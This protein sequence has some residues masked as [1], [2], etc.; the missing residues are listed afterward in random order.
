MTKFTL[1]LLSALLLLRASPA[2]AG[3]ISPI[4]VPEYCCRGG[5]G[6]GG[7]RSGTRSRGSG[8]RA[9]SYGTRSLSHSGRGSTSHS[10]RIRASR[11]SGASLPHATRATKTRT[12]AV[13]RSAHVY[14]PGERNSRGRLERSSAAKSSFERQTG[15]AGGWPGHV[16]DHIVPL[17]CG[18]SDASSNMQWQTTADGKAKD[19][20]ERR[21]CGSAHRH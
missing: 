3:T 16:V 18:G 17:A 6:G 7:A 19:R 13:P 11:P 20:V 8:A 21:G 9:R 15:H 14:A 2:A 4:S 10:P 12:Y 1:H 5:H